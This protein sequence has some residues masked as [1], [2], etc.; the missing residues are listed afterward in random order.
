[1]RM[2][3]TMIFVYFW[4]AGLLEALLALDRL[5]VTSSVRR[6]LR[7]WP[8]IFARIEESLESHSLA[9]EDVDPGNSTEGTLYFL[10]RDR[11]GFGDGEA[12]SMAVAH[13]RGFRFVS[14]DLKAVSAIRALGVDVLDW[15]DVLSE[16]LRLRIITAAQ[17]A[18]GL[19]QIRG[20]MRGR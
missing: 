5:G 3:D 2:V 1:V 8:E 13:S 17:H 7:R 11:D 10:Y 4:R 9:L 16:L 20:F 18:V 14:H 6:E 19:R 12:T 15:P